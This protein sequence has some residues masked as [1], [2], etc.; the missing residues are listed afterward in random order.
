[1]FPILEMESENGAATEPHWSRSS[2]SVPAMTASKPHPQQQ[3]VNDE[4]ED[5]E[6]D[7]SDDEDLR[8][9][10]EFKLELEIL[11]LLARLFDWAT[12]LL[13]GLVVIRRLLKL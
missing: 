10:E 3:R 2:A 4:N 7:D 6:D 12:Q 11:T 1:M 5:G 8:D 9:L 13:A